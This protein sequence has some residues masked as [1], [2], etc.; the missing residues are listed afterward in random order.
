MFLVKS[1]KVLTLLKF[2]EYKI[3]FGSECFVFP[4]ANKNTNIKTY[5]LAFVASEYE[6]CCFT[7]R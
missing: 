1:E 3:L 7:F 2:E 6:T 4:L 5:S